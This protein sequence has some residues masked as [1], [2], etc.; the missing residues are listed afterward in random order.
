MLYFDAFSGVA[1]DMVVAA[2]VDLGVPQHVVEQAVRSLDIQG[3]RLQFHHGHVGS[4]GALKFDVEVGSGQTERDYATIDRMLQ[5]AD[6]DPAVRSTA[7]TIFRRLAEAEA[8]VHRTEIDAVHFHEVGAVDSIADI[9]GAAACIEY[10]GAS[11]WCSPLPMGRGFIQCRHGTIP[12]PAPATVQCLSGISTRDA[13]I[14]VELVTPTG[15]AILGALCERCVAWPEFTPMAVGWGAGTRVLPDRPN[16]LRVVLGEANNGPHE[17]D[18]SVGHVVIEANVDDATGELAGHALGLL[19]DEGALDA[20]AV[21]ITMKKGRPGVVLSAIVAPGDEA[22]LTALLIRETTTLGVRRHLAGRTVRPRRMIE[23]STQYGAIPVKISEGPFGPP[24]LKPEFD[25]CVQRAREFNL[26]V[27]E[28]ISCAAS[29][30]RTVLE[31]DGPASP[32]E[33]SQG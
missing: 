4:I 24:Q 12:L 21:P 17:Q 27:R 5:N 2:L 25:V 23:V 20:W 10:I 29:R 6:L 15:A 22:R 14:E 30:A 11:V 7:R 13:G 19:L 31:L 3:C 33:P 26:P 18:E 1:G 8:A 16:V 28:I 9:V 32:S